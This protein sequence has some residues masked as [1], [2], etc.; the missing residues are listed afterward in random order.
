[1]RSINFALISVFQSAKERF[2]WHGSFRLISKITFK[3]LFEG[4][5]TEASFIEDARR[6]ATA[7][8]G[9]NLEKK[10]RKGEGSIAGT[11]GEVPE[12]MQC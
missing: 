6:F 1:M 11:G 12:R 2:S 7:E 5:T 10:E 8:A 9:D 4:T 3:K